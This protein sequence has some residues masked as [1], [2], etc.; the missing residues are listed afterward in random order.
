MS[1]HIKWLDMFR[2]NST[3]AHIVTYQYNYIYYTY[4]FSLTEWHHT[5]SQTSI[6][7]APFK[8]MKISALWSSF[9]FSSA[10]G[11]GNPL[12]KFVQNN[13]SQINNLLRIT[14]I[15]NSLGNKNQI[16]L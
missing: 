13:I 15:W 11:Q 4:L 5:H 9:S 16:G 8:F 3:S 2:I 7:C 1:D 14:I 6:P 10:Y 12:I